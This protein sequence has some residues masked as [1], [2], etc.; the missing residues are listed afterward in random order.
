MYRVGV[1]GCRGIGMAHSQGLEGLENAGLVAACDLSE[2]QLDTFEARW[3]DTWPEMVRYTSHREMPEAAELDIVTVATSDHRHADLVA[4]GPRPGLKVFSAKSRWR[5][6]WP[7]PTGWWRRA[8]AIAAG[9]QELVRLV[10]QGGE[11]VSLGKAG[12]TVVEII[13][14]FLESQRQGNAPI[15]IPLPRV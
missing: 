6:V 12:H 5:R 10:D 3:Q 15:H 4:D 11:P 7:T 2:E 13:I 9:V 8:S 14:G 1:I